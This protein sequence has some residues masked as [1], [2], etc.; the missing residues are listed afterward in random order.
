MA[1]FDPD[2]AE[3]QAAKEMV[4]AWTA[5]LS[6]NGANTLAHQVCGGVRN[7]AS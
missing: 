4:Y 3:V 6:P 5:G 7:V 2:I 1:E